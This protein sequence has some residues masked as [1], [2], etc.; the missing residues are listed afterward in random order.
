MK[1]KA[2]APVVS[3]HCDSCQDVGEPTEVRTI[4]GIQVRIC[5]NAVLCRRRAET[6]GIWMVTDWRGAA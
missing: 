6:A 2:N 1:A 4:D 3:S 5:V